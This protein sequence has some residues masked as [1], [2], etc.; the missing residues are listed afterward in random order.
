MN[1]YSIW[2]S[3]EYFSSIFI[4]NKHEIITIPQS[5][6][7][8]GTTTINSLERLVYAYYFIRRRSATDRSGLRLSPEIIAHRQHRWKLHT[9]MV[10]RCRRRHIVRRERSENILL[11]TKLI[12][13]RLRGGI[14]HLY[15]LAFTLIPKCVY[16]CVRVACAFAGVC[17]FTGAHAS[18]AHMRGPMIVRPDCVD[19][20]AREPAE[21][22]RAH[23]HTRWLARTLNPRAQ[24]TGADR[25]ARLS[26]TTTITTIAIHHPPPCVRS[27]CLAG[28]CA[29]VICLRRTAWTAAL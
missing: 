12:F 17:V 15:E 25:R 2:F 4:N 29:S 11:N 21:Y 22:A 14:K 23:A 5:E 6:N 7:K 9:H 13:S 8:L 10:R 24:S 20:R 19:A 18:R 26:A 27:A 16:L 28:W 1:L 3:S